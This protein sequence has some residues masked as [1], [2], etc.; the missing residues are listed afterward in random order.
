L[1]EPI[2]STDSRLWIEFRSS[3]NWVGKG[4]SAVYEETDECSK[5]DNGRCEQRCVNTL[6]SYKCACDPG[7]ELAADK[8]SCEGWPREYPPNKNCIWQLVAPT[9]YRITLLFDVFETEGNDVRTGVF[10]S[11]YGVGLFCALSS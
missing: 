11:R 9:Q 5:P 10:I 2:I 3:S 6:G 4:F 7:Y 1:P 8:R